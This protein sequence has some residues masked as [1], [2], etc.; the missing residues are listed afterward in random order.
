MKVEPRRPD[1]SRVHSPRYT[2]YG[3]PGRVSLRGSIALGALRDKLTMVEVACAHC[4]RRGRLNLD[5]HE[6]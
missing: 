1:N 3:L 4:E 5:G 2:G 6:H